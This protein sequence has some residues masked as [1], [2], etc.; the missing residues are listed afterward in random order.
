MVGL[1]GVEEQVGTYT[2]R[3]FVDTALVRLMVRKGA[4]EQPLEGVFEHTATQLERLVP[5]EQIPSQI[6][7]KNDLATTGLER[8]KLW[9][10]E[11]LFNREDTWGLALVKEGTKEELEGWILVRSCHQG[12][13][14][15]PLYAET[16][17]NAKLLLHQTMRR[18]EDADGSY[19]AEVWPSNPDAVAV[20]EESGWEWAG[21]DYHRM[22]LNGVVPQAQQK[23]GKAEKEMFAIFDAAQ[24]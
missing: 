3:G 20:F 5:L 16:K 22:W 8:G 15:G 13:R 19:I 7:V 9:T 21:V 11:A 12:F 14:I 23:A 24:G 18:L 17:A 6:L 4:K 2:R 1:D 10:K